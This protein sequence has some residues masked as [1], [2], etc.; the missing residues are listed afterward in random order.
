MTAKA[1]AHAKVDPRVY[2]ASSRVYLHGK[3]AK[4]KKGQISLADAVAL[5]DLEP[6]LPEI[7]EETAIKAYKQKIQR[8]LEV[9]RKT[10]QARF[11]SDEK[12]I[13]E[14]Y[15]VEM[16]KTSDQLVID[17]DFTLADLLRTVTKKKLEQKDEIKSF[18]KMF[19]MQKQ[20]ETN[21]RQAKSNPPAELVDAMLAEAKGLGSK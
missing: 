21:A 10:T 18:K 5:R 13:Q 3:E 19:E 11:L 9:F 15:N 20:S 6:P 17:F 4:S 16:S 12:S 14:M 2:G 1:C 7:D 8:D